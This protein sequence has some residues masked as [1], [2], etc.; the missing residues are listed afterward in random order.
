MIDDLKEI[1][2]NGA[3]KT[4]DFG[5]KMSKDI[6]G[7]EII[8]LSGELGAGKTTFSQGLLRGLGVVGAITSPTFTVMKHYSLKESPRG[9]KNIF[10]IDTYRVESEDILNIGWD[11][12]I[13]NKENIILVEWPEKIKEII[14]Q[15]AIWLNFES[16][17][18]EERKITHIHH[19]KLR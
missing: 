9:L 19:P 7:G 2:T 10:H 6:K 12:I 4:R 1:I 18:K 17:N 16:I 8:C 3:R 15:D 13:K 11:E 5:K 14:P